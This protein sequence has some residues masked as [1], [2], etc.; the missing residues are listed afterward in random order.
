LINFLVKFKIDL[1]FQLLFLIAKNN[2]SKLTPAYFLNLPYFNYKKNS[3]QTL[4]TI[5]KLKAQAVR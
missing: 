3:Y 5:K 2:F 4:I 1:N